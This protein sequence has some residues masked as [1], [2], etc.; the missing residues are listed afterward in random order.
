MQSITA[1]GVVRSGG[2]KGSGAAPA[3]VVS[4]IDRR[5]RKPRRTDPKSEP[6]IRKRCGSRAGWMA[7]QYYH[8]TPCDGCAEAHADYHREYSRTHKKG[9]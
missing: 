7:H 4:K 8:E 5:T 2:L 1:A 6:V 9:H 3:V